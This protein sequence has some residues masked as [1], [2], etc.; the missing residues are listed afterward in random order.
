MTEYIVTGGTGFLGRNVVPRLLERDDTA[1]VHV[2][3]RRASAARLTELARD[4][5]GSDRIRPLIGDLTE[6]DLGL[7]GEAPQADHVVH[8]GAVYDMTAGPEQAATNI[9]GTRAVIDLA[10]R[11]GA[12]LHHVSS[13][14]VSGD[15]SGRFEETDFDLGQD[16]PTHYHRTKFEAEKLVREADGLR[17]RIYRPGVVV[18]DSVTGEINKIDGPYYFF[19]LIDALAKLPS[20]L[21]VVIPDVGRTNIVP[22]DYVAS[23]LVELMHRDGRDG[24]TFHLVNPRPQ[25][26]S[27]IYGA[28]ARA[29]GA[30]RLAA[31]IPAGFLQPILSA[32]G[33]RRLE[34]ARSVLLRRLGLPPALLDSAAMRANFDSRRTERALLHTGITVP[35]FAS[36]AANLW[37]YWAANL[38]PDRAR[39]DHPAGRLVDRNVLITGAS[40]G[41]GRA[42]AIAVAGKGARVFLVARRAEEL[43]ELVERIRREGGHAY[44]Y[45]CDITESE[46]VEQVVKAIISEH[47]HVDMLVNNAG[48]SIRRSIYRST[49]RLHDFERTM[50]VN[51]FG[52]VA[53]TLALL[54]HMRERRFG[55]IVNVS[56][57]GVQISPPRFAAYLA[58]KAALEKFAEVT[59]SETLTDGITFTNVRLPLVNTEMIAPTGDQNVG[60]MESPEWAAATIVR[61][62]TERPHRIDVP[63]GTAT[64]YF[65]LIAPRLK[66]RVLH[67]YYL[68]VPDSPAAKGEDPGDDDSG[69]ASLPSLPRI[70]VP[71]APARAARAALR[72]A[73]RWVPGTQW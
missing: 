71:S 32:P 41:I 70:P 57:A 33:D 34:A 59:A 66:D 13:I 29:A 1:V 72:R 48:R 18:G 20:L 51:Y 37:R 3:V 4:W 36:Y 69:P 27:E 49:D 30:P 31:G 15:H 25:P 73:G 7:E 55:H 11:S 42:T 28:L 39:H 47:G 16:F 6:P 8:L 40:S 58:S 17:Y 64:E 67:M 14:A 52:A 12:V 5:H 50:A 53:L 21:P 43:D 61:A 24:E 10:R 44:A 19:P 62:L 46:A 60:P 65:A 35:V 23:A 54:P 9:D 63:L 22:V 38:D 56:S 26:I 2:L 68:A 45:P